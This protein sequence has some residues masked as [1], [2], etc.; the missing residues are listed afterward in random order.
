MNLSVANVWV[1]YIK[2]LHGLEYKCSVDRTITFISKQTNQDNMVQSMQELMGVVFCE[3]VDASVF[4]QAKKKRSK[5]SKMYIKCQQDG[6]R[7][8]NRCSK[9]RI[10]NRLGRMKWQVMGIWI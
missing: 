10:W 2:R 8:C 5:T 7:D 6:S 9:G 4:D 3:G 1:N